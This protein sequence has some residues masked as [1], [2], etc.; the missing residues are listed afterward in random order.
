VATGTESK[1]LAKVQLRAN[2]EIKPLRL[3]S[4]TPPGLPHAE[5][6]ENEGQSSRLFS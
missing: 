3:S 1:L 5:T 6:L 4:W 2:R